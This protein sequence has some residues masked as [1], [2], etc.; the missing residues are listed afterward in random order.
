MKHF[1]LLSLAIWC[2]GIE[3]T[4][5]AEDP[6]ILLAATGKVM[7][8]S[9]E[10]ARPVQVMPGALLLVGG[11]ISIRGRGDAT[12]QYKKSL[13]FYEGTNFTLLADVVGAGRSSKILGFPGDFAERVEDAFVIAYYDQDNASSP[14]YGIKRQKGMGDGWG[15]K[16]DTSKAVVIRTGDGWGIKKDTSGSVN[17]RTGD[18]WGIK[19]DTSKAVAIRTGDG[20]GIKGGAGDTSKAVV[21]RTGDGWGIKS[22]TSQT[23]VIRT[24]DGWTIKGDTGD[25]SKAVVIRTGDGWTVKGV[26]GVKS[27]VVMQ[28]IVNGWGIKGGPSDTSQMAVIRTGD[29]WTIKGGTGD[30]S[31]AIVIRT[32]D[33]WSNTFDPAITA[34]APFGF[35]TFGQYQFSWLSLKGPNQ[36]IIEVLDAEGIVKVKRMTD[37]TSVNILITEDA[38]SIGEYYSWRVRGAGAVQ[39]ESN[40]MSF[41]VADPAEKSA[42]V[43]RAERS[44]LYSQSTPAVK[45]MMKG[46]AYEKAEWYG[47]ALQA[48]QASRKLQGKNN[49]PSRLMEATYWKNQQMDQATK[50]AFGRR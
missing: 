29:G 13:R 23:V 35:V 44:S 26:P 50:H 28:P 14:L 20:W 34:T 47:D 21:I 33:G 16:T 3:P 37:Q 45:E 9:S 19:S 31:Q 36:Y 25:T 6:V 48:Y 32:G 1:F 4:F 22:D 27:A 41:Y 49:M 7:Y 5:A 42:V 24:G 30:T 40:R 39:L 2:L 11:Y 43:E 38:F 15:I 17:V 18:G 46:V 8:K 10:N 12:L